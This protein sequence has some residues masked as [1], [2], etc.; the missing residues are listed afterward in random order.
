MLEELETEPILSSAILEILLAWRRGEAIVPVHF[1]QSIRPVILAQCQL[2][3]E[4]F[5][6]GRWCPAWRHHQAAHYINI[7][8]RKSSLRWATA[9]IHKLHLTAW[10]L[11]QYRNH[12]LHECAGPCELALHS[13]FNADIDTEFALGSATL[14]AV[15]RY[16]IDSR[17]LV[18]LHNDS[19]DGKRQ[20]LQSVRAAR[21]AFA[22][23]LGT[24]STAPTA[25]ATMFCAWLGLSA[26][27]P[28]AS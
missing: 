12:R 22:D 2:G 25:Q 6:L 26:N 1:A 5:V 13:S 17:S 15:S 3:W 16:L 4:N 10:D 21:K 14:A 23:Q 20:W 18:D 8:S 28:S 9:L 27:A 11:W 7:D 19:L 24:P